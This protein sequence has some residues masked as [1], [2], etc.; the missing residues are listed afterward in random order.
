VANGP[1]FVSR[2]CRFPRVIHS[3]KIPCCCYG[4]LS[5]VL[6]FFFVQ[7]DFPFAV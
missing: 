6:I 2:P 7:S 1:P 3:T 5:I 4:R